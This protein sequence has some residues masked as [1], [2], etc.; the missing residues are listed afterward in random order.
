MN[1]KKKVI[2]SF[3]ERQMIEKYAK[4]AHSSKEI[5]KFLGRSKNI[6]NRE[7]RGCQGR[8][9]YT[10]IQSQKLADERRERRVSNLKKPASEEMVKRFLILHQEKVSFVH[11]LRELKISFFTLNKLYK[12][13]DLVRP[14][15]VGIITEMTDKL[16]ALEEQIKILFEM[17]EDDRKN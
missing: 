7:F 16:Y 4:S 2:L 11:I 3:E 1:Y 6:V 9:N 15:I 17:V 12:Q 8:Q 14:S 5:G 10:A 13:T